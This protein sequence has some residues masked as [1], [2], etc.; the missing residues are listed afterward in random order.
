MAQHDFDVAN[1][2]GSTVRADINALGA[3][4]QSQNSGTSAPTA[5]AA[6]MT[7]LDTT[8]N[9]MKQRNSGNSAW[10]SQAEAIASGPLA[11]MRN[12]IINGAMKIWQ[13]YTGAG[14][15]FSAGAALAYSVDRWY[16]YCTG[17]NVTGARITS[18]AEN[19]YR[20]T[21][22]ASNTGVGFGQRIE[23]ANSMDLA[24]RICTLSCKLSSTS[25]TTVTWTAYYANGSDNFGSLAS[26]N[27]TQIA[28]GTF[29]ITST[30]ASYNAQISVPAAATTGIEIV[31]TGGALLASQTL[32]IGD[33]Q[34]EQGGV[35]TPFEVR[36]FGIELSA[37]QRYFEN[38]KQPLFYMALGA[39]GIAS[40]YDEIRFLV[41]KRSGV[42]V[43][44]SGWTYYSGGTGVAFTPG[45][46]PNDD[47][48]TWANTGLTNWNGW[49][50][51]GTW[52]ADAEL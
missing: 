29:S 48:F 5:T 35:A 23:A 43:A 15:T 28:T 4:L 51:N 11:G 39:T 27:R 40:A 34:F 2:S 7:W 14:Q 20:F 18:G 52:T 10:I 46:S 16:G 9:A 31:F 38:G 41:R 13:R 8:N 47:G 42:S 24:N 26:P 25:L 37:C 50:G 33:V 12:R 44:A 3:A 21:G 6:G 32:I 30:E 49:A 22:A 19:R 17:A 1:G 36:L 45:I